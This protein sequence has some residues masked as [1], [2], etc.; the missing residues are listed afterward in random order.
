MAEHAPYAA[1]TLKGRERIRLSE[2]ARREGIARITAYRMLKRG[3]LPVP[4][5]RS[6]TG[7]WYVLVNTASVGKAAIYACAAAGPMQVAD[8]NNQIAALSEWMSERRMSAFTVVREIL[9]QEAGE[10][11]GLERLLSDREITWIVIAH[12]EI[13]GVSHYRLLVSALHPQGRAILSASP[14]I[15]S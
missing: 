2:W 12:P 13:I 14:S 11:P 10:R 15:G 7:R 8:I 9:H 4:T 5:E 3:L 6:P 1:A